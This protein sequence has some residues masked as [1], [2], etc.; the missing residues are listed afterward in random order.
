[1]ADIYDTKYLNSLSTKGYEE[2]WKVEW[3]WAADKIEFTNEKDKDLDE[4]GQVDSIDKLTSEINNGRMHDIDKIIGSDIIKQETI[5]INTQSTDAVKG[6]LEE[7]DLTRL[8]FSPQNIEAIQIMIRYYV[9]KMT[10][11]EI[12]S[13]QSPDELFIVMRSIVLQY[14]NFLS[15]NVVTEIKRLNSKV[16]TICSEKIAIELDQY[17]KYIIDLQQLPV[18]LDNPHYANKNNF[19]YDLANLPE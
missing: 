11:G 6:I 1:M 4:F 14:A 3:P 18:P 7:T 13:N 5:I 10:G 16:V 8:F 2:A 17:N 15:S 12:I 9:N 19:T